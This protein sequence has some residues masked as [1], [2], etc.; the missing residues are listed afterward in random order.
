MQQPEDVTFSQARHRLLE[1]MSEEWGVG[2]DTVLR[3][4]DRN[5]EFAQRINTAALNVSSPMSI[6]IH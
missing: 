3:E 5:A 4:Y 2:L 1:A 6:E